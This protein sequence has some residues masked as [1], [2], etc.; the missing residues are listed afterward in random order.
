MNVPSTA[1]LTAEPHEPHWVSRSAFQIIV[2]ALTFTNVAMIAAL[3]H[4]NYWLAVPLALIASHFMH[5]LLIGFHEA[6]HGMLRQNRTFNNFDGVLIGILSF[7]SFTL[8]RASH[9]THHMHLA[10]EKDE[11]L[12]PFTDTKSPRWVRVFAAFL[13]LNA[14][15]FFTPYLFMRSFFR[16]D[17]PIRAKKVRRRI[18][19]ELLLM[20]LFW[21]TVVSVVAWFGLWKYLIWMHFI[22]GFIAGN[23]QSWRKYI[24]HV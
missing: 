12:W 13:E 17:S 8:Y 5:G 21:T 1:E 7:M 10:T 23:L 14:G 20:V 24:E 22:P 3:Y 11:E 16:K 15:L 2:F 6:S 18:W 4:N 9:Q 19:N